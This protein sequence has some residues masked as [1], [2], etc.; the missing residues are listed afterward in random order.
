M[1]D[2]AIIVKCTL[3]EDVRRFRVSYNCNFTEFVNTVGR[4]YKINSFVLKYTDDDGDLITLTSDQ[5][6]QEAFR[7]AKTLNPQVLRLTV[8]SSQPMTE[9]VFSV[10][11]TNL[12]EMKPMEIKDKKSAPPPAPS[13]PNP[14]PSQITPP[15]AKRQVEP[16][17]KTSSSTPIHSSEPHLIQLDPPKEESKPAPPPSVSDE[18]WMKTYLK[19]F[20]DTASKAEQI[21]QQMAQ[22]SS[23]LCKK[24]AETVEQMAS[25]TAHSTAALCNEHANKTLS[26]VDQT[27][28]QRQAELSSLDQFL[29]NLNQLAVTTYQKTSELSQ[30]IARQSLQLAETTLQS[31]KKDS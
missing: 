17:I 10:E 31:E 1:S 4:L 25:Q 12:P 2:E 28:S 20:T 7:F 19:L 29:A 30:E 18:E 24:V 13:Q 5:E 16:Y 8:H 27:K 23:Q 15:P 21:S 6:L 14:A 9:Q 3:G 22:S 26:L 11:K